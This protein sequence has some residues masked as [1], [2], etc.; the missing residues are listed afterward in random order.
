M[1]AVSEMVE[2]EV[3]I[4]RGRVHGRQPRVEDGFLVFS[5]LPWGFFFFFFYV[6]LFFLGLNVRRNKAAQQAAEPKRSK[7]SGSWFT[8]GLE[9]ETNTNKYFF[10]V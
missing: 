9:T 3:E 4:K 7:T 10:Y 8:A 6:F 1:T 2:T 5:L